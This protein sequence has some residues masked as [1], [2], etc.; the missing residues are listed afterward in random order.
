ML[1]LLRGMPHAFTLRCPHCGQ[2]WIPHHYFALHERCASCGLAFQVDEGDF[3]GSMVFSYTFG[4]LAGLALAALAFVLDVGSI[5]ARV[6]TVAFLALATVLASFPVSRS[7][8]VH[9]LYLTRGHY[10]EYRPP[11]EGGQG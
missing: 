1:R 11:E 8:W 6:Y 9:L 7:L 2:G 5:E 3:W 10:E 4:G